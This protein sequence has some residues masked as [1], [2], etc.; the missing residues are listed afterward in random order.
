MSLSRPFPSRVTKCFARQPSSARRED[1][2][3]PV[4]ASSSSSVAAPPPM[5]DSSVRSNAVARNVGLCG[6]VLRVIALILAD[7]RGNSNASCA[8][9]QG[10]ITVRINLC[11]FRIFGFIVYIMLWYAKDIFIYVKDK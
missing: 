3:S 10:E 7:F 5:H 4:A 6:R 8:A 11:I 1:C 9:G 2:P